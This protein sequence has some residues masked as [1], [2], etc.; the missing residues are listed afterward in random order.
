[1][2]KSKLNSSFKKKILAGRQHFSDKIR[3]LKLTNNG[4]IQIISS[5]LVF[6]NNY[7]SCSSVSVS[8]WKN[9]VKKI[10]KIFKYEIQTFEGFNDDR[11]NKI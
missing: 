5:R 8:A 9:Q 10:L 3:F 2:L 11:I 6:Y 4:F 1:M 7:L